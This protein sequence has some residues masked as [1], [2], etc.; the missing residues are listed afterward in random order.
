M[1]GS[2]FRHERIPIPSAVL[3]AVE[4][5]MLASGY[6]SPQGRAGSWVAF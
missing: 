5:T 4:M 3:G 6:G 1:S 2:K